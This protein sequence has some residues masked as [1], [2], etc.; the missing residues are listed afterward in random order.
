M[1]YNYPL[2]CRKFKDEEMRYNYPLTCR[3]FKDGEMQYNYPLTWRKLKDE[4]MRYNYPS[5]FRKFKNNEN[6]RHMSACADCAGWHESILC[7]NASSPLFHRAWLIWLW[8]QCIHKIQFVWQP[9]KWWSRSVPRNADNW[10]IEKQLGSMV[11]LCRLRR[12]G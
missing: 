1:R 2:T 10:P 4:E 9:I 6:F 7:T 12:Q 3:K 5:T 11:S 8:V